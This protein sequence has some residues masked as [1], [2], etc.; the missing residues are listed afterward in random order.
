MQNAAVYFGLAFESRG[1][2]TVNICVQQR[3]FSFLRTLG[4][5]NFSQSVSQVVNNIIKSQEKMTKR[6]FFI[7]REKLTILL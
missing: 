4:M 2:S 3:L 7:P 5:T 1:H 6:F